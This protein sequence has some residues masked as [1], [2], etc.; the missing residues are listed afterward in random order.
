MKS[1]RFFILVLLILLTSGLVLMTERG[2]ETTHS[3]SIQT[4]LSISSSAFSR[5]SEENPAPS[6]PVSANEKQMQDLIQSALHTI[7]THEDLEK[8]PADQLHFTPPRIMEAGFAIG[9]IFDQIVEHPELKKQGLHFFETCANN[10]HY[11]ESARA[12][13]YSHLQE[14]TSEQ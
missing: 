13:C 5:Q 14:L 9:K 7:P 11:I 1:K 4:S 12:L 10:D 2:N 3:E 6:L 8:I